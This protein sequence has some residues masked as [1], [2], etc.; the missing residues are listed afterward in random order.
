MEKETICPLCYENRTYLLSD[1]SYSGEYG[2]IRKQHGPI[3][4]FCS[5]QIVKV[6]AKKSV[7]RWVIY[8]TIDLCM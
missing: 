7:I 3:C 5:K 4:L 2:A 1:V 6:I 8:D